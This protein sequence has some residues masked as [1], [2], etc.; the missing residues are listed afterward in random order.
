MDYWL[1][2]LPSAA[3]GAVEQHLMTCDGCGDRL[4]EVIAMAEGLRALARS[5]SLQVV[6]SDL[7]VKH[8]AETG[9]ARAGIRPSARGRRSSARW[10]PTTTCSWRVWQW[11]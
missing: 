5:G 8:A 7:F 11:I 6:V 3:E 1:A 4:R 2:A 10:P 9:L